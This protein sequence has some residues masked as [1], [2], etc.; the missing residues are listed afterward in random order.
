MKEEQRGGEPGMQDVAPVQRAGGGAANRRGALLDP[1]S[2]LWFQRGISALFPLSPQ[3]VCS[4]TRS[5][6]G[7]WFLFCCRSTS[8]FG[9]LLYFDP[10]RS[11]AEHRWTSHWSYR[12]APL[13][14]GRTVGCPTSSALLHR[15]HSF[16]APGLNKTFLICPSVCFPVVQMWTKNWALYKKIHCLWSDWKSL[17]KKKQQTLHF[18]QVFHL[19][20]NSFLWYPTFNFQQK[21][22]S[23]WKCSFY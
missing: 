17:N 4:W 2:P 22:E 5:R 15:A 11:S 9:T 13:K 19:S 16:C 6:T 23:Q 1:N 14:D 12:V 21:R 8:K 3:K 7:L 20:Q 18:T 10:I